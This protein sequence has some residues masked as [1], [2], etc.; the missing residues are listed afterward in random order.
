MDT[1]IITTI[2]V[3]VSAVFSFI[4]ARFFKLPGAI[5]VISIAVVVSVIAVF[6][7]EVFPVLFKTLTGLNNHIDFS[8]TLLNTMLGFLLFASALRFNWGELKKQIGAV[9][10]LS[11]V[12]VVLSTFIFGVL[13]NWLTNLVKVEI[14]FIYCLLFGA[15]IS[16]T[17]PVAV[18]A[19]LKKSN[20]P[21]HLETIITG[22]SLFN[23]G[24][25]LILFVSVLEYI[26]QTGDQVHP[27]KIA[28]LFAQEVFGGIALGTFLAFIAYRVMRKVDD[29][30]TLVMVSLAL[31][32]GISVLANKLHLSIPLAVVSAGLLIGNLRF[33]K[34]PSGKL[35]DFLEKFWMII[36]ELLNTIL[37]VMIGLQIVM[38]PFLTHYWL[39]CIGAVLIILIARGL[40]ISVPVVFLRRTLNVNYNNVGI[41]T[42]AGVRG[43]IS[44]ALA[45]SIPNSRY[46]EVIEAGCYFIVIF[47]VV[48]QG[49][50][51]NKVT[52]IFVKK[53]PL[54]SPQLE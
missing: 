54:H 51:L 30:Q 38:M 20:M 15:L 10:I 5:G 18:S 42:W 13:F 43:G 25:G 16:P 19:V 29:F 48:V 52:D 8:Q 34:D 31:V 41:L 32:M 21:K 39:I 7:G 37:F 36:D 14:P 4:N 28:A 45:L 35:N 1:F 3:V 46:K 53:Q 2:L 11:T 40:S 22:E 49:L 27:S 12:G 24:I 26:S 9:F 33:G 6:T 44:I 47:S 23:D 17:D 50:T